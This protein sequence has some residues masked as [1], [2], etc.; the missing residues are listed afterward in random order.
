MDKLSTIKEEENFDSTM[1]NTGFELAPSNSTN[2]VDNAMI[3][4]EPHDA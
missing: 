1:K 3:K 2:L 4:H